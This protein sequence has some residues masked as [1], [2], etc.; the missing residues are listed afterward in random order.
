MKSRTIRRNFN[1]PYTPNHS[2]EWIQ[3]GKEYYDNLVQ[4]IDSASAEIHLQ[5]YIFNEDA[6]GK[7][8]ADALLRAADRG[9]RIFVLI[10]AYG[11]QGMGNTFQKTLEKAGINIKRYGEIFSRGRFHISRR[12]HRKIL[13]VDSSIAVVGGINI[14]DHYAGT[15][16]VPAWLDFAVIVKGRI[17]LRLE[18]ICR[19]R[20]SSVHFPKKKAIETLPEKSDFSVSV[21]VRRNDFIRN[22]HEIAIS[23]RQAIRHAEK[24]LLIVGGY[25]L[26][27][28][29]TRRLLR[30]AVRRGVDVCILVAEK[31]D[32]GI[33][34]NARRYLYSWLTTNGIRVYEYKPSN[35]HGKVLIR[36][37][38]WTTIG[39]YDLN[40]LST[41][42]NIELNLDI[43][44]VRF[45]E[46]LSNHIKSIIA[47]ES[48]EITV[49]STLLRRNIFTRFTAWASYRFVKIMFVLSFVLAGKHEKDF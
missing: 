23:Y 1:K 28:G 4:I 2:I 21:R 16:K 26:P 42:S 39:S 22:H 35:V 25:F 43:N 14:S 32:V 34:L 30:N 15:S 18:M 47:N 11:S 46:S 41:Y 49:K 10:D 7:K 8:I 6:T 24:S 27:G 38:K 33:M 40:N 17:S 12:L 44:N 29:R 37:E 31:S 3:S 13:V 20:W 5:T 36:D 45:S 9:V 19:K 48:T